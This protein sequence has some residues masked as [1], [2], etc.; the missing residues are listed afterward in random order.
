MHFPADNPTEITIRSASGTGNYY[1]PNGGD[2][3]THGS[4]QPGFRG[5]HPA[6]GVRKMFFTWIR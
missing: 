2:W 1:L 3:T 6:T 4:G 5:T